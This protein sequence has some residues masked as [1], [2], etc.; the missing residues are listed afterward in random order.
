MRVSGKHNDLDNVGPSHVHHTFFQ[1]LGNF[2]FGDYFKAE[3]IA[4]A[5]TLLTG[6]WKMPPDRLVVSVFKGEDGIP[7]DDEAYTIWR[8]FVPADRILE[9]GGE[10]N[11]W[12]M[13]DTGPCGRCSEIYY[14]RDRGA[15]PEV[16]IWNNVFMEFDRGVDGVLRPLPAPSIDTGMGLERVTAV[17]QGKASNYDT[18]LFMPLLTEIGRLSGH[19]YG[20]TMDAADVSMRVI[21]DHI[22]ATTFPSATV[23]SRPTNGAATC[24]GRSCAARCATEI[25]SA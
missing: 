7:R 10:D 2:S 15:N 25:A 12:Q 23:S 3:A 18:D 16:E 4:F 11:F 24:C 9:L 20:G 14:V 13:G 21:A 19:R 1:M 17:M 22:R 8:K 6:V 5:W